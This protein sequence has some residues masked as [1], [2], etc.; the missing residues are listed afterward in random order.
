M[1]L[2]DRRLHILATSVR[3]AYIGG[4]SNGQSKAVV[5]DLVLLVRQEGLCDVHNLR[6][7]VYV[8]C[9]MYLNAKNNL[10]S[11]QFVHSASLYRG[12]ERAGIV[13]EMLHLHRAT[14]P[15]SA[16]SSLEEREGEGSKERGGGGLPM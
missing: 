14:P 12:D 7:N 2:K 10:V 8:V 6:L 9:C 13:V 4:F 5:H 1:N 11:H 16:N 15:G 3:G